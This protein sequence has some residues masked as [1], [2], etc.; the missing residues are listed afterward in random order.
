MPFDS[1][2]TPKSADRIVLEKAR[3]RIAR[4]WCQRLRFG[5]NGSVCIVGALQV[6]TGLEGIGSNVGAYRA[7]VPWQALLGFSNVGDDVADCWNDAKGRTQAEVLA[8]F[9][10]A[11]SRLASAQ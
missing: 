9:D 5:D 11:I 7:T 2:I 6:A 4:G 10:E 3:E 1:E 8:R